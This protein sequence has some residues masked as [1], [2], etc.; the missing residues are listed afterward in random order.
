MLTKL[1]CVVLTFNRW[2]ELLPA[3]LDA[4]D[5]SGASLLD[6]KIVIDNGAQDPVK[7]PAGWEVLRVEENSGNIFGQNFA[8]GLAGPLGRVLFVSDDVR[9]LPG[10]LQQLVETEHPYAM[11]TILSEDETIQSAGGDIRWPLYGVN[12]RRWSGYRVDYI[13]SICYVM[14][15]GVIKENFDTTLPGAYEDVD[16]G[17]RVRKRGVEPVCLPWA[18]ATHLGNATLQY[19]RKDRWRFRQG[20]RMLMRKHGSPAVVALSYVAP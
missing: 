7:V 20:R 9:L 19:S 10:C 13:P 12:R 14:D 4:I 11:P 3:C 17:I 2:K 5:D 16:M 8:L 6:R 1:S 15:R 18:E